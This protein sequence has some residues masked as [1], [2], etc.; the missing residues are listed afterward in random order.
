[1]KIGS[2]DFC[3]YIKPL[4][5]YKEKKPA[6]LFH[7]AGGKLGRFIV[8]AVEIDSVRPFDSTTGILV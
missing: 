1:M 6:G 7:D 5:R 8:T 3:E 2:Q 4:T